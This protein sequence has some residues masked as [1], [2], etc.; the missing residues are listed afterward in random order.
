[1]LARMVYEEWLRT[2]P[3]GVLRVLS[4]PCST[5]E[6]PY[7]VAMALLDAGFP[8]ERFRVDAL[9]ISLRALAFAR[10]GVFGRN[11]FRGGDLEFRERHFTAAGAGWQ[12]GEVARQPVEFR[13]GNV[14]DTHLQPGAA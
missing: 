13:Q 9:D 7:S 11:S 10:R 12:L 2:H 1:A 3:D 14:L 8:A 6:E 5:G 4:L